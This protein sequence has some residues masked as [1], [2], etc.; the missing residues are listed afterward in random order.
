MRAPRTTERVVRVLRRT[1]LAFFGV[2]VVLAVT[3]SLVDSYR[4]RGKKPKPFPV[5]SPVTA[6]S[7]ISRSISSPKNSMRTAC[8]S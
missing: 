1:L 8:S 4:R 7:V 6:C 2:Q 5:T 3:M